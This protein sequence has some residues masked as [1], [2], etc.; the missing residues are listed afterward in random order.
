MSNDAWD[1]ISKKSRYQEFKV[2]PNLNAGIPSP[3]KKYSLYERRWQIVVIPRR[4]FTGTDDQGEKYNEEDAIVLSDSLYGEAALR[5][6]F[7]VTSAQTVPTYGD[8]TV[9]NLNE[10][11][12]SRITKEGARVVVMAGYRN[13]NYGIIWNG[14]L[15]SFMEY[16]ENVTDKVLLLHCMGGKDVIAPSFISGTL[17]EVTGKTMQDRVT[18]LTKQMKIELKETETLTKEKAKL[19]K[20]QLY[21]G[22]PERYLHDEAKTYGCQRTADKEGKYCISNIITDTGSVEIVISP[23]SGLIGIP[24]QVMKGISFRTLLDSRLIYDIPPM[25]VRID[26]SEIKAM[27]QMYG[28]IP[29]WMDEYGRYRVISVTHSGDT[30]G[31]EWYSDVEAWVNPDQLADR[32]I[33]TRYDNPV[34]RPTA[35][36]GE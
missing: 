5:V 7:K 16:R 4:A 20:P 18:Y 3:Y 31:Q 35:N 24:T 13:G 34:N 25:N 8:I 23:S 32:G 22:N 15:F 21:F 6:K 30:R 29:E 9:Y 19:T 33:A 1:R 27:P 2:D 11:T 12:V 10:K 26:N 28:V 14:N 36:S 17:T